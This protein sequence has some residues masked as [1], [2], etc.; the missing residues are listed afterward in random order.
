ML[1]K[2]VKLLVKYLFKEN[3]TDMKATLVA[4]YAEGCEKAGY[5]AAP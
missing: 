5:E 4:A 3:G 2:R 1:R